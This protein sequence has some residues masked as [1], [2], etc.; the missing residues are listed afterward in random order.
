MEST[1]RDGYLS[2]PWKD[3]RNENKLFPIALKTQSEKT[4]MKISSD[5]NLS[6]AHT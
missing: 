5:L 2:H 6:I 4:K 3:N 1:R